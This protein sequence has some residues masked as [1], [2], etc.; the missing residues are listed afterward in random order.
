MVTQNHFVIPAT[1]F[2]KFRFQRVSLKPLFNVIVHK[3]TTNAARSEMSIM[4]L[5]RV[6]S[7][8]SDVIA[9]C[10]NVIQPLKRERDGGDQGLGAEWRAHDRRRARRHLPTDRT[11]N[12]G[13]IFWYREVQLD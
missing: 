10:E 3:C 13:P 6:D 4:P 7:Q 12:S 2:E 1:V 8:L 5:G 11:V 9:R